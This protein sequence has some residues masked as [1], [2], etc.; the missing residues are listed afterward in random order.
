M[1][2]DKTFFFADYEGLR[3]STS[4]PTGN[5]TISLPA[6]QGSIHNPVTCAV[7][8]PITA[9]P[10]IA[11]ILG[12]GNR[13]TGIYPVP[14]VVPSVPT[15][16]NG[17]GDYGIYTFNA[18]RI[19]HENFVIGRFDQ[20]FSEHDSF[21]TSYMF[22]D[23]AFTN[24][25]EYN[26]KALGQASRRQNLTLE[27]TH[28]FSPFVLNIARGG[29]SR[30]YAAQALTTTIFNPLLK[31]PSLS[32]GP[33]PA[34][35]LIT[36]S[37]GGLPQFS[38]GLGAPDFNTF[39]YNSF[40][41]YDDVYITVGRNALKFG[42]GVEH[43]QDNWI[44]P[45]Q[46]GGAWTFP[47]L[48]AFLTNAPSQFASQLKGTDI[49]RRLHQTIVGIY[50]QDDWLLRPNL[51][52]N[53][54]MRWEM[55]TVPTDVNGETSNLFHLT[56][57]A[58]YIGPLFHNP[59]KKNF[60][61]RI[62]LS[63]DPIGDGKTAVRSAFGIFDDL[64][65]AYIFVNRVPRTPPFYEAGTAKPTT[66]GCGTTTPF[67]FPAGGY[68]CL[69]P[70]TFRT[71][72]VQQNPARAYKMEWNL[73]IQR[74]VTPTTMV[75]VGYVGSRGVHL[76]RAVED[77]DTVE[78]IGFINGHWTFPAPTVPATCQRIN[79]NFSRVAADIWDGDSYY[80]GL[81]AVARK[82]L[83]HG[84]Q[85]QVAFTWSK[86]MDDS[87]VTFSDN[88]FIQ[89]IGNPFPLNAKFNRGL[90]DFD[91]GRNLSVNLLYTFPTAT[92]LSAAPRAILGGWEAA[93][94]LSVH[95]GSPFTAVLTTDRANNQSSQVGAQQLGERPDLNLSGA[96]CNGSLTNPGNV[97]N[98]IN[99][100]CFAF[101]AANT[102]G[103]EGRNSL[104]GPGYMDWDFSLYKNGHF[105]IRSESVGVQFRVEAFNVVNHPNFAL[106]S[107]SDFAIFNGTGSLIPNPGRLRQIQGN[108]RQ[109]Q[110]GLKF[111][112]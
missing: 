15:P 100:H 43:D 6:Q 95:D 25:D 102:L 33:I 51:T 10:A 73:N 37:A 21:N 97:T 108:Q 67:R 72:Y 39:W 59:T 16:Q 36:I 17:C 65:L 35:G 85:G 7:L 93:G 83:G 90:S 103:N 12:G 79:C 2:K 112:F 66:P 84:L 49:H 76:P 106:P 78:P 42:V 99:G 44:S 40:Q 98:Y 56:D 22:D 77:A 28:I 13:G 8:P 54:G 89:T 26:N 71:I 9:N 70:N 19:S 11:K 1:K 96:G 32:F 101:P 23:A 50:A 60:E 64:P 68:P 69:T 47:S 45:N 4:T 92:S 63:W 48:Q 53:L 20:R 24:P 57:P 46:G 41:G 94:I 14:Q 5:T 87:S 52:L 58:V 55:S 30:T 38:G 91:V 110:F 27:E 61:P 29:Y 111:T 62:G 80:E 34:I 105:S 18:N 74:Q 86:S 104:I 31:D 82:S 3:D 75:S 88:E 81:Q 107:Y 109:I